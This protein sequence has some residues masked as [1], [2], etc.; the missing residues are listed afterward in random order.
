MCIKPSEV[1][2]QSSV[3]TSPVNPIYSLLK[4][5]CYYVSFSDPVTILPGPALKGN[6]A[7]SDD[8]TNGGTNTVFS[9]E[10]T[11]AI[12]LLTTFLKSHL[13]DHMPDISLPSRMQRNSRMQIDAQTVRALEIKEGMDGGGV[14]GSLISAIN[15]TVTQSGSRLLTRWICEWCKHSPI[16]K[17]L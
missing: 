16:K 3:H 6:L 12:S 4:E 10:E 8:I 11:C 5:E 1:V 7:E 14:T 2:L 9:E 15:R 17:P 13:L